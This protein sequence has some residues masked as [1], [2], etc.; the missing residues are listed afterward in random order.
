MENHKEI[1]DFTESC[2]RH[3]PNSTLSFCSLSSEDESSITLS[4]APISFAD[5]SLLD[6]LVAPTIQSADRQPADSNQDGSKRREQQV[7]I[8]LKQLLTALQYMHQR[9]MVHLD[10]RPEAILLQDDH[11]RLADF[12][13]SRHLLRGKVNGNI[14]STPEFVSPEIVQGKTVTQ[15]ADM[16]SAG[17]LTFVLLAGVSPFLGDNDTETLDNVV[18]GNYSLEI[19][20]M[21]DISPEAKDFL[22]HLLVLDPRKR[23]SVDEAE[24]KYRHNWLER[25]VFVQQTPSDQLTQL[26]EQPRV[27]SSQNQGCQTPPPPPL[28]DKP[29][30]SRA[31]QIGGR[32]NPE[33][34]AWLLAQLPPGVKPEDLIQWAQDPNRSVLPPGLVSGG[35]PPRSRSSSAERKRLQPQSKGETPSAVPKSQRPKQAEMQQLPQLPIQLIRGERRQIEEE[36]ANRILSDISEEN[37]IAGSMASAD[38]LADIHKQRE[39]LAKLLQTQLLNQKILR[40]RSSTPQNDATSETG[41]TTPLA[42]PA[43]TIESTSNLDPSAQQF[44]YQDQKEPLGNQQIP[45]DAPLFLDSQ[46]L[47]SLGE[48][49]L[50][51]RFL[52]SPLVSTGQKSAVSLSPGQLPKEHIMSA[53][54]AARQ[55]KENELEPVKK[56]KIGAIPEIPP[57]RGEKAKPA[58]Q[59]KLP[60]GRAMMGKDKLRVEPPRGED[61]KKKFKSPADMEYDMLMG[62]VNRIKS[63]LKADKAAMDELDKYRPKNFYKEENIESKPHDIDLDSYGWETNYQIGPDTLLLA[64]KGA[65]FNARVRDYRRELWGDAAP[66]VYGGILG[67]RNADITVRERRRFTDLVREDPNIAKSVANVVQDLQSKKQGALRRIQDEIRQLAPE[68][69]NKSVDG[70]FGAIFRCRLKDVCFHDGV[71]AF[72]LRCEAI[73]NPPPEITFFHHESALVE[74]GRHKVTRNGDII[75][76]TI[77]SPLPTDKGEYSCTAFNE[78]GGD[79]CSCTVLYGDPPGRP[80]RP[81]VELSAD[82]EVFVRWDPPE[83]LATTLEGVIYRVEC[84][85]AGENDA[86][87][88]WTVIS[89]RVED[90][91]AVIKHLQPL[92]VY[93]FRVTAKNGFGWG[94][95]SITSRIIRTHP[96][97]TP[98]LSLDSLQRET[99]FSVITMP[100]R[101][102]RRG[103][104]LTEIREESEEAGEIEEEETGDES[105][106]T[107]HTSDTDRKR[108]INA[109]IELNSTEDPLKRFQLESELFRGQFSVVRLAV[110]SKSGRHCAAKIRATARASMGGSSDADNV[111]REYETLA[112]AQ[113]DNVVRLVAAYNSNNFLLLFTERLYENVFDRFTYSDTYTEEQVCITIRQLASALHWIHFKGIAHLDV[114]P[115]NVMFASKRSWK[116]KLID[117]GPRFQTLSKLG[118]PSQPQSPTKLQQI[119]ARKPT[120][121]HFNQFAEWTAP[122]VLLAKKSGSLAGLKTPATPPTSTQANTQTDMWGLGLITFCLLGGF[123][124]FASDEDSEADVEENVLKQKCDPNLVPVQ[125]S[126]EALRFATWALKK[127]PHRRMRLRKPWLIAFLPVMQP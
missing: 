111:L 81:E 98:K 47:E 74:D 92:G 62:E 6:S 101:S 84:R 61:W 109:K 96:K 18:K 9:N 87:A 77:L 85:P 95:A 48:A 15:A 7:R 27:S 4:L 79:K 59:P 34:P 35:P 70:K 26:I 94:E 57:F 21:G 14:K 1:A 2:S 28:P 108:E 56:E 65:E 90:E 123:H 100:Q 122:E 91:A 73:G 58:E 78:L 124:P 33:F 118:L 40:S 119:P 76:L 19:P 20:E 68:P 24:F 106:S 93:Q 13:Q 30:D 127:D 64:T 125:A 71:S 49:G 55:A 11:L 97:G 25:R 102:S 43:F 69:Q 114:E 29:I 32:K 16:W 38:E 67:E 112:E 12:G 8:F 80:S 31:P 17:A 37:S 126:E 120:P 88:S 105:A 53:V 41:T 83:R 46:L 66:Y 121:A 45:I 86:F 72:E 75:S 117:F 36:I 110:D 50:I 60:P 54:I 5:K 22:Q 63:N 3:S 52:G 115:S 104:G 10:L 116:V 39:E 44:Q 99:R 42:S 107:D 103:T 82:T 51:E 113:H 23:M 89:N